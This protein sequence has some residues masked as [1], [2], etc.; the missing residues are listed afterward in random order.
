MPLLAEVRFAVTCAMT[1]AHEQLASLAPLAHLKTVVLDFFHPYKWDK[2]SVLR[3][4]SL[5]S[6]PPSVTKLVLC[7]FDRCVPAVA[8]PENIDVVY[9]KSLLE[10]NFHSGRA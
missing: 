10:W 3:P 8:L 1:A 6:L 5:L 4:D 7:S 2:E 9:E